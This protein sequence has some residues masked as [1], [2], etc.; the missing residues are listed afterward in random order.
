M[1]SAIVVDAA[2]YLVASKGK[3]N[4]SALSACQRCRHISLHAGA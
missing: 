1:A 4:S 3:V 2:N